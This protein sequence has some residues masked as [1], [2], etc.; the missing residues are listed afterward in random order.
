MGNDMIGLDRDVN[1]CDGLSRVLRDS[2]G[3]HII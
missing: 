1:T 2:I 3:K